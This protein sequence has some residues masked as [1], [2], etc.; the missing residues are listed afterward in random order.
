MVTNSIVTINDDAFEAV[1]GVIEK[2]EKEFGLEDTALLP[3]YNNIIFDS[4][5]DAA[6]K[7]MQMLITERKDTPWRLMMSNG[8]MIMSISVYDGRSFSQEKVGKSMDE[9]AQESRFS[10][11]GSCADCSSDCHGHHHEGCD[12]DECRAEEF[13]LDETAD[14]FNDLIRSADKDFYPTLVSAYFEELNRFVHD[15][16]GEDADDVEDLFRNNIALT[17]LSAACADGAYT[18]TEHDIVEGLIGETD[19]ERLKRS[20]PDL[21]PDTDDLK[22]SMKYWHEAQ[23]FGYEIRRYILMICT[24]VCCADGDLNAAERSFLEMLSEI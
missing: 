13:S 15:Q 17:V 9:I 8:E 11:S 19:F 5:E 23:S 14:M 4:T 7:L 12:C 3:E 21:L 18:M 20:L 10:C 2:Y 22:Q 6:E 1:S 16:S 24:Y